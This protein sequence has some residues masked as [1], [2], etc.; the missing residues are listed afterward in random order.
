VAVSG[1]PGSG[2]SAG[3]RVNINPGEGQ[4]E[5]SPTST[6][7]KG[8]RVEPSHVT[9]HTRET[10]EKKTAAAQKVAKKSPKKKD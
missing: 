10:R 1:K 9:E 4:K 2:K 5:R 8:S 3:Q 6:P 7:H